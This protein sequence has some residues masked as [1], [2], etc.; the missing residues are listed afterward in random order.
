[1][2]KCM[3][4]RVMEQSPVNV[5]LV[6]SVNTLLEQ[7]DSVVSAPLNPSDDTS[8]SVRLSTVRVSIIL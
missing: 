3:N 7:A 4:F 6:E 5:P 8:L 2:I 1:M